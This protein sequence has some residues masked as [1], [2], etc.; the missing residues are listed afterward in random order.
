MQFKIFIDTQYNIST[1]AH[2][3]FLIQSNNKL[4]ACTSF[5]YN[6]ITYTLVSVHIEL[7]LIWWIISCHEKLVWLLVE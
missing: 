7:F 5:S 4:G 6:V 3:L 1:T 2:Q